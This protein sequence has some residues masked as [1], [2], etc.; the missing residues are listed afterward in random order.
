GFSEALI[1]IGLGLLTMLAFSPWRYLS[2]GTPERREIRRL[3]KLLRD[4]EFDSRQA[5]ISG[6]ASD[7]DDD[8]GA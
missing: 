3:T 4:F 5:R 2:E 7:R 6:L 8:I 1:A